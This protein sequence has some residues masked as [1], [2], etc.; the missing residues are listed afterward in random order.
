MDRNGSRLY[1]WTGYV[2]YIIGLLTTFAV[3]YIFR[4]A[5]VSVSIK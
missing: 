4:H 1:F 3:L 5:Q 2:A